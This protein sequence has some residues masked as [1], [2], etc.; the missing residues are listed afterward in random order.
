VNEGEYLDLK[1]R[2][3]IYNFVTRQPGLHLDEISKKMNIPKDN[4][5]YHLGY[6][7]KLG[8]LMEIFD[9]E[10]ARYYV[11][12]KIS[13]REREMLHLLRQDVPIKIIMFLLINPEASWMN[14]SRHLKRHPK[15]IS[16]HL[17]KLIAAGA[18]ETI[19]NGREIRYAVKNEEDIFY[20][21]NKYGEGFSDDKGNYLEIL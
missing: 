13:E 21:L 12:K 16:F 5:S 1:T 19:P 7:K 6:L 4:I 17:R 2:G 18:I 20:L 10:N 15:T 3:D 8:V 11:T 14:I 9:D